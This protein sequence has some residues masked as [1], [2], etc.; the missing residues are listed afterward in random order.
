MAENTRDVAFRRI[1][2]TP[3]DQ[4]EQIERERRIRADHDVHRG[5]RIQAQ[6]R[7]DR[8][9]D[10]APARERIGRPEPERNVLR[11]RLLRGE[12][13]EPAIDEV[14][15]G[16]L[17]EAA[18]QTILGGEQRLDER[19][20]AERRGAADAVGRRGVE[21]DAVLASRGAHGRSRQQ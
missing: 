13:V 1:A 6:P 8:P 16:P 15:P 2:Q 7:V 18:A 20:L 11:G 12:S 21:G 19:L 9:Q 4:V 10:F 5:I 3:A 17:I 14:G